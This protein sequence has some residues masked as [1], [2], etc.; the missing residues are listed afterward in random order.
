[1]ESARAVDKGCHSVDD[2]CR[3]SSAECRVPIAR[4]RNKA[5]R[6]PMKFKSKS[7]GPRFGWV[8]NISQ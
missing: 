3:V 1:M 6:S 8:A 5:R 4:C 2:V 7:K